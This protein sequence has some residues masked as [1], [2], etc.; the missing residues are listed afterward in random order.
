MTPERL[1]DLDKYF[2]GLRAINAKALAAKEA[3]ARQTLFGRPPKVRRKRKPKPHVDGQYLTL[4]QA[5]AKLNIS[6]K[7]LLEHV[8]SGT[9]RYITIGQGK[10]R[11]T[12]R[13]TPADLD[14]FTEQQRQ[15]ATPWPSTKT[16]ARRSTPTSSGSAVIDIAARL[17]SAANAKRK[18]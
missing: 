12:Y 5:T 7:T 4:E 18:R 3:L 15:E 13:F 16:A 8:K 10:K 11:R 14:R 9:L 6:T 17:R 1:N 2:T